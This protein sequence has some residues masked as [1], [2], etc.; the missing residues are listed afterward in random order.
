MI[1]ILDANVIVA[2]PLLRGSQ[3]EQIA[4]A[5]LGKRM[6]VLLPRFAME[7][8]VAVYQRRREAKKVEIKSASRHTSPGVRALLDQALQAL[9]AEARDYPQR[10]DVALKR[11]GVQIYRTPGIGHAALVSMAAS[12]RRP[13]DENGSGYRDALHWATVLEVMKE[14]YEEADVVFVSNDRRAF[15]AG[16]PNTGELHPHLLEDLEPFDARPPWFQWI[17]TIEEL[18]VPG[19]FAESLGYEINLTPGE[20]AGFTLSALRDADPIELAP[21]D[22]GLSGDPSAVTVLDIVDPDVDEI[23]V[24]QYFDEERF[25]ADFNLTFTLELALWFLPGTDGNEEVREDQLALRFSSSAHAN[26]TFGSRTTEYE[27]SQLELEEIHRLVSEPT[28][29][30]ARPKRPTYASGPVLTS[31]YRESVSSRAS[32]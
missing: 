14:R 7:E 13:F 12:R 17:R 28:A 30:P 2:N 27:F 24:R 3:W 32:E 16:G 1:V 6:E 31:P 8:G 20:L 25:R 22:L 4:E 19:V 5:I 18:P 29:E 10:L 11:T 26:F 9:D 15:G 21:R 23:E